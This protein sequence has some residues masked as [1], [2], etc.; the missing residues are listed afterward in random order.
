M[1]R[2]ISLSLAIA[3]LLALALAMP[4]TAAPAAWS[5]PVEVV[6]GQFF[7]V[8]TA[9]DSTNA[10]HIVAAGRNGLWYATNRSGLWVVHRILVNPTNKTYD[11]PSIA[12]DA[13]DRVY[14]AFI[15]TSCDDCVPGSS[16]GIY[17]LTDKGRTRGTFAATPIKIA[18]AT[19]AEPSLA[20]GGGHIYLAY[21]S[22]CCQ[23]GPLPPLWFKTNASGSWTTTQ[24]VGH[25]DS[26]SLKLGSNAHV[27]IAYTKPTGIGFATAT[28][29]TGGFSRVKLPGTGSSDH[30]PV[31]ALA[32]SNRPHVVWIH[33]NAASADVRYS[34]RVSGVWSGPTNIV[35]S[36]SLQAI[37]LTL[38]ALDRPEVAI[39][40]NP[41]NVRVAH[42]VSGTWSFTAISSAN[43]LDVAIARG[44]TGRLA[45]VYS[46]AAGGVFVAT[47]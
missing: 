23:P 6:T 38:D 31:L 42:L 16:D 3:T 24:I 4:A 28:T 17:Y 35:T 46:R 34:R 36:A 43:P 27:R 2:S 1:S 20:V 40:T 41:G 5:S 13:N 15:R 47:N 12:L 9:V 37:G 44:G 29:A 14:I 22:L 25:G 45:V 8:S 10:V 19:S 18:P 26:P 21:Q 39:G 32:A 30:S 33:D 7:E 11:Q